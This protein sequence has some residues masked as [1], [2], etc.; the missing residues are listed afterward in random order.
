[1]EASHKLQRANLDFFCLCFLH[2]FFVKFKVQDEF[3]NPQTERFPKLSLITQFGQLQA[4]KIR[5]K[6]FKWESKPDTNLCLITGE[7][8]HSWSFAW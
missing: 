4:E 2:D 1:M 7:V 3:C 5:F 8:L 6:F